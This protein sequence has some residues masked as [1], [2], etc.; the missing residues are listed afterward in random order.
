MLSDMTELG[1]D[2]DHRVIDSLSHFYVVLSFPLREGNYLRRQNAERWQEE[3]S[4][5]D[6]GN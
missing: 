3:R 6:A 2:L 4:N 5:L 1:Y